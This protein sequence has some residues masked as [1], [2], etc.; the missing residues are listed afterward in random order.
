MVY[1]EYLPWNVR[2]V[3]ETTRARQVA[4]QLE[5]HS[6]VPVVDLLPALLKA[7]PEE[8]LYDRT[9]THWNDY[10]AYVAYREILAGLGLP[11]LPLEAFSIERR[12]GPA[13]PFLNLLEIRDLLSEEYIRFVPNTSRIARQ[14]DGPPDGKRWLRGMPPSEIVKVTGDPALPRALV[15]H[16]SFTTINLELFLSEHFERVY[17]R[18]C[19]HFDRKLVESERPNIVIE[20]RSGCSRVRENAVSFSSSTISTFTTTTVQRLPMRRCSR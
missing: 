17:Y 12:V 14:A 6:N 11:S 7:K 1:P 3:R 8:R 9:G 4:A 18:W 2:L 10:G 19:Y 5:A 15:F 16:D 13:R 20:E